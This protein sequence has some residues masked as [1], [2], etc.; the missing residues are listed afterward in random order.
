MYNHAHDYSMNVGAEGPVFCAGADLDE[1]IPLRTRTKQPA[2][3][4]EREVSARFEHYLGS[5]L[6]RNFD[7]GKP[8]ICAANGHALAGGFELLL[9]CDLRVVASG[10]KYGLPE[11]GKGQYLCD[12][13]HFRLVR[14][15]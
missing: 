8:V 5:A 2:T 11:T 1:L 7:I 4:H 9:G 14:L 13:A 3:L 15:V 10:S 6:L 12:A